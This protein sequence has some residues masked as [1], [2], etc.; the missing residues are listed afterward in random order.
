VKF[1]YQRYEIDASSTNPN[2]VLYRPELPIRAIG[3]STEKSLFA[4]ADTGADETLLPLSIGRKI[5]ALIEESQKSTIE[6]F[7]GHA[8]EEFPGEVEFE[9]AFR[10]K[11]K[12]WRA[13]VGFVAFLDP[14]N[15]LAVLG[16]VGF[17]DH[18]IV[19]FD[20]RGRQMTVTPYKNGR[21]AWN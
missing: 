3:S 21:N 16:H 1:P 6:A 11:T 15:E 14:I 19:Q 10:R 5:G 12:R 20:T 9:L 18:F 17:F 13:K 8:I 4:R 7:G 2:A